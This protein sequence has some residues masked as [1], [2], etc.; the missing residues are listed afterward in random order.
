[1]DDRE[2]KNMD[3]KSHRVLYEAIDEIHRR[4]RYG[5]K[6]DLLAL[7]TLRGVGRVRARE[8]VNLLGVS[9]VK[10]VASMTENDKIKLSELRGWSMKLVDN[11]VNNA[12]QVSKRI[13]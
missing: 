2:L 10:D 4:V 1:M 12:S 8:M 5:C 6:S 9:N 11:T 3:I 13:K 7:I